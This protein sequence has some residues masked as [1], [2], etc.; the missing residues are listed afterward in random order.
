VAVVA[1]EALAV[2]ESVSDGMFSVVSAPDFVVPVDALTDVPAGATLATSLARGD[3][4]SARDLHS[5]RVQSLRLR[6]TDR[7]IG[8][9]IDD[10]TPT[11]HPGDLIELL[12]VTTDLTTGRAV[13]PRNGAVLAVDDASITVAVAADD[14]DTIAAVLVDGAVVVALRQPD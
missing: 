2:G 9:P 13:E 3:I 11:L 7:A 14:A 10:A 8:I 5:T 4:L 6:S 12:L 1:S